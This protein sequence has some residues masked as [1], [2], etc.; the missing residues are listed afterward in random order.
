MLVSIC[1]TTSNAFSLQGRSIRFL[2][3]AFNTLGEA[4]VATD[5]QGNL[6]L[7]DLTKNKFSLVHKI[8]TPST[9]LAFCLRR[10]NE[11]LVSLADYSLRCYDVESHELISWMKGHDAA[12][13]CISIHAS[14]R[15]ALTS[16]S[17]VI[18]LWDLDTFTR[19]RTLNGAQTVG[20][21]KGFFLPLSNTI[22]TCF[23][24]D[25]IFA[26]DS[27]SLNCKYQLPIPPDDGKSPHYKDLAT[28][29][30]GRVLVAGGRSRFLHVWS[31]ETKRIM[32]VIQLP[33]KI[34]AVKQVN[35]I[36]NTF[37][38]G[39]S[40]TIGVLAQDGVV[41]FIDVHT[42]KLLFDIGGNDQMINTMVFSP[43]GRYIAAMMDNGNINVY[44]VPALTQQLSKPPPP[45]VK[46][47]IDERPGSKQSN[48][49][50]VSLSRSNKQ[51]KVTRKMPKAH[52]NKPGDTVA[53]DTLPSQDSG[54]ESETPQGLN[55]NRLISIL[56]AYGE[57]PSKYRMFIWR[58]LLK[59]PENHSSYSSLVDKGIHSAYVQIH[60]EFP[61]KSR[62]LLRVLQRTLSSLAHWSSLFGEVDYLPLLV[63]PFVKLFQNNQLI[64][65]EIVGSVLTSW[66]QYWFEYFPNPPVSVLGM[67]ENVLAHH[68][69]TLMQHFINYKVTSKMY[70]WPL[71]QT[72]MS[73][74]LTKDEWLRVW[75]NVFSNHPSFL[76][77][78]VVAYVTS[79][80][81]AL[82]QC[83]VKEDFEYFFHNR[84]ALDI[85]AV[86][87]EAYRL[88]D[89]TPADIHPKRMLEP[90]APLT[91][92][93]YPI[94][95]KY[96]KFVVDYQVQEKE[97]IRQ[98][99]L[100]YLR[101]RQIA[102]E[103]KDQT[104]QRQTEEAA[105][106]RQQDLM[107]DAEEQRR[108]MIAEE[109]T[110]LVDQRKRVQAMKREVQLREL[111]LLD[112]ARR[113]HLHYQQSQREAEL[114]RLD[115]EIE[116]K[117]L[118]REQETEAAIEDVEIK[119]LELQ[120]QKEMLQQDMIRDELQSS[121]KQR[122]D[123]NTHRKQQELDDALYRRTLDTMQEV[124]LDSE[125][126]A[127]E[128]LAKVQSKRQD[129][130][131]EEEFQL[132]IQLEE[133]ERELDRVK[134]TK[135]VMENKGRE[136]ELQTLTRQL[137]NKENDQAAATMSR[138][139]QHKLEVAQDERRRMLNQ[140]SVDTSRSEDESFERLRD[141]RRP[142]P[143]LQPMNNV[144]NYISTE[145]SDMS[146]P[147]N[148]EPSIDRK[149]ATFE[150]RELE[151]MSEVR[152][153]R[154]RLAARRTIPPPEY[155]MSDVDTSVQ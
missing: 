105:F 55:R 83:T 109:D 131:R 120:A 145:G 25:S 133:R 71:L 68:D 10:N 101:Q 73:E 149:R 134:L 151:L 137:E 127:Q 146:T 130:D 26:W 108:R 41:R 102:R 51:T 23:K 34:R 97:R 14:G 78:M 77:M 29:R 106:Y 4:F 76:L 15:Y 46:T 57:Y 129:L 144:T 13:H 31:L 82:L 93:Q 38:G 122:T 6:Y 53:A 152:D 33:T 28:S 124:D 45:V 9:A 58:S 19:K 16:S 94:F 103:M 107:L 40:Q 150:K 126:I 135:R 50:I 49:S 74:V 8:G 1:N 80:R 147:T 125:R 136:L 24:D 118:L 5:H 113:R 2:H 64:C 39:C 117:S 155:I 96:P 62:K 12:I 17:T 88:Q 100:E 123:L 32:H 11:V 81:K 142:P 65:F 47:V 70:A 36:S 54:L 85:S 35:F 37:D 115:D 140:R 30:D 56:R 43:N 138:L 148:S 91:K 132:K 22:I 3:A 42:C 99:E 69:K 18:Q 87:R 104:Q 7:F 60:E 89:N 67:M 92:A 27:E 72:L 139:R 63:F 52:K 110:K 59:L 44:S 61:I 119:S 90:F 112:A 48:K 21:Q 153:L 128:D 98:E 121:F 95:N 79:S 141:I 114:R 84:N 111:Q 143:S 66:C 75:D 154:Q 86:V 20:I 116:R